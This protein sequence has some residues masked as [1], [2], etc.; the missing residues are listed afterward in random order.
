VTNGLNLARQEMPLL[1]VQEQ[2]AA[3][4]PRAYRPHTT[5]KPAAFDW[6]ALTPT[7]KTCGI[8]TGTVNTRTGQCATCDPPEVVVKKQ[9]RPAAPARAPRRAGRPRLPLDVAAVIEAYTGGQT[10]PDIAEALDVDRARVREAIV[11][12]GIELRDDRG[13]HWA[14]RTCPHG[15]TR[16][17][18]CA[19]CRE[20]RLAS[21]RT[22]RPRPST[23]NTR[24]PIDE[25]AA[26]AA[27]L[28][29][30]STPKVAATFGCTPKR[31]RDLLV[32]HGI[33]LR[34]DRKTFSG[35]RPKEYDPALVERVRDLYLRQ[36]LSQERT[37]FKL[38]VG[39]KVVQRVMER[40]GIPA[41]QGQCS[42]QDGAVGLRQQMADL[43]VTSREIKNWALE[44]GLVD[45]IAVGLP[46]RQ[47]VTAYADTHRQAGAA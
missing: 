2:H 1:T 31:I 45:R 38:G 10:I 27:Y 7:C 25:H 12:A 20:T 41:R 9:P 11:D 30:D 29:G 44:V 43:G 33:E 15:L 36:Q 16:D 37:A 14:T 34:D 8:K 5:T 39:I 47:L 42:H 32:R 35:S 46:S 6:N 18:D 26:V 23:A 3:Q 4:A 28:A 22:N 40:Y 21:R 24:N 13:R 19:D 17:A